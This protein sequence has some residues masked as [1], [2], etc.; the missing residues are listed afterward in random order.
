MYTLMTGGVLNY[1]YTIVT[2]VKR[3]K[4]KNGPRTLKFQESGFGG[5]AKVIYGTYISYPN[6]LNASLIYRETEFLT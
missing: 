2:R 1:S 4:G 5:I 6:F 3:A